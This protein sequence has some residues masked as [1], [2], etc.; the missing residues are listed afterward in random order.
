MRG[1]WSPSFERT[2]LS[3]VSHG[4]QKHGV[5]FSPCVPCAAD[6]QFS[7]VFSVSEVVL[8]Y[9]TVSPLALYVA[10]FNTLR[11]YVR[12]ILKARMPLTFLLYTADMFFFPPRSPAE[13]NTMSLVR[14]RWEHLLRQTTRMRSFTSGA[15]AG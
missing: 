9:S 14:Y 1:A 7:Y 11:A 2:R 5:V 12:R 10:R 4:A 15:V 13:S 8:W 3:R 6:A